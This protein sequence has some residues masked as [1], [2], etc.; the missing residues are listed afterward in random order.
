[1]TADRTRP[2]PG[3]HTA[4]GAPGGG[5]H[6]YHDQSMFPRGWRVSAPG[7]ADSAGFSTAEAA[8]AAGRKRYGAAD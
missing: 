5:F 1:M 8:Y 6:V 2:A 4:P 3:R 7:D